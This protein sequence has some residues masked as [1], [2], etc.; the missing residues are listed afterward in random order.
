[1]VLDAEEFASHVLDVK[2]TALLKLI[3]LEMFGHDMSWASF[4][5]LEVMS[6]PKYLQKRV[7]Y[8][9]AVQSFRPDTEVLMLA[10]NLLKKDISSPSMPTISL[11]LI[12]LPHIVTPSIALSLLTD[13]MPRLS[14]SSPNIRKKTLVTLY[15]LALVYPETLRPA[16]PKIKDMLMDVDED[17]SVT[18]AIINVICE[19]GCRR[20]QDFLPLA[21]R[22][23]NLLVDG[24][25]N[26]MAIKIIKLFAVL[27]PL[28]PRLIKKLLPPLVVL[29]RTTPAMSLLYECINGIIQGGILEG[30]EGVPEGDEVAELCVGKLRGMIAVEGDPNLKYVALLAFNKIVASHPYLVS[31]HQ[32]VIMDC[33][34]DPDI[35]IRLQ[36]L[37]LGSG[38]I[39]GEN[40]TAVVDRLM[41]QLREATSQGSMAPRYHDRNTSDGVE[42]TADSD[43]ADPEQILRSSNLRQ[44]DS[45]LMPDEYRTTIIR[46][47][48]AM[49]S[50]DTY[51]NI[52]DFEWYIDVLVELVQLVPQS[53]RA[54]ASSLEQNKPSARSAL[55]VSAAIGTELRNVAV[56]VNSVRAEA[57]RAAALLVGDRRKQMSAMET[58]CN[59][60]AVL[61]YAAWIVGEYADCLSNR[62]DTLSYLLV[63]TVQSFDS[64]I[65]CAY[66]QSI[67]KIFASLISEATQW[68][69][70]WQ[71]VYSL[72]LARIIHF[73]E[74]LA[75][76]PNL[77]VQERSVEFLELMR[78]AAEAVMNHGTQHEVGPRLLTHGLP[79]LFNE[80]A[81]NPVATTAQRKVPSPNDIDLASPISHKL[82]EVLIRAEVD[83]FMDKDSFE[84]EQF[85]Y[86]RTT[87]QGNPEIDVET[88]KSPL[89]KSASYQQDAESMLDP[90]TIALKRT[91]RHERNKDDPFY[92][93]NDDELS[94]GNATPTHNILKSSNGQDM[95]I[96]SIP[97][98]DLDFTNKSINTYSSEVE[99]RKPK[100]KSKQKVH[101]AA[102]E[103]IDY[104]GVGTDGNAVD[105]A[106]TTENS[107][108]ASRRENPKKSLLEV[109]SSGI[110]KLRLDNDSS[111]IKKRRSDYDRQELEETEMAK[112]MEEVER[113]RMEMQRAAE[114]IQVAGDIPAD[115]TLVKKKMKKKG[116]PIVGAATEDE[117]GVRSPGA[118]IENTTNDE[119]VIKR[120]KKKKKKFL[121]T[122]D[123]EQEVTAKQS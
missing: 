48:L 82:T 110:G 61:A 14:H 59:G 9:G 46:Q 42:P 40:L 109:D 75:I 86:H 11:P 67:A 53:A 83:I 98:M 97:I 7:G 23:F 95:D 107:A 28:E 90:Q 13:L 50:H 113:L 72:L 65:L 100:R 121:E 105:L 33:I 21:P 79:S 62:Q 34:D 26:W 38:M 102:D 3:Y 115:G 45:T 71:T 51:T 103:N 63:P 54:L 18:A 69:A 41:R 25:N 106:G 52:T 56:R 70:A 10:T 5:V 49:C 4:N 84:T 94:S 6:S 122:V 119:V 92:I 44:E 64:E 87:I 35:S 96:D 37:D 68:S 16:W 114:R 55:E 81:L 123:S 118:G 111:G 15:R 29:I 89:E 116:K 36:A 22:L 1:M 58:G 31:V 80:S 47:I 20:P 104:D 93:P 74:P 120:K 39:N 8:L 112:A 30:A 43:G 2:A 19:L 27:T 101:I 91:K 66:I 57:V 60:H 76:H 117:I 12:T 99:A 108:N 73:L 17:P 77:E 24:G 32:D 85:Y 78:L 88:L